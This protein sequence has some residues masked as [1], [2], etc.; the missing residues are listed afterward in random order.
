MMFLIQVSVLV[1]DHVSDINLHA[2]DEYNNSGN[3]LIKCI[4]AARFFVLIS[5]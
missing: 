1:G 2:T 4:N 3:N 5:H